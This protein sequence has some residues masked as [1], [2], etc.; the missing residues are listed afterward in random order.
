MSKELKMLIVSL[1]GLILGIIFMYWQQ[2]YECSTIEYQ[3]LQGTHSQY[4]CH[5]KLPANCWNQ[6]HTEDA[7]IK[8]CEKH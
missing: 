1:L 3:D 5:K 2:N 7:A 6:Y 8:A 4:E